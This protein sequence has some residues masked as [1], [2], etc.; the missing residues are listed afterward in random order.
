[1]FVRAVELDRE[2]VPSFAEHPFDL[3]AIRNLG[4]L[5]LRAPV[6]CFVGENGTGKST[7]LEA[8]A[9]ACGF[10]PEGG[11]RNLR[12]QTRASHSPLHRFVRVVRGTRRPRTGF[13]LRAETFYNLATAVDSIDEDP[14]NAG[15]NSGPPV[16]DAY[17]GRSLHAQ[18][19]GESFFSLFLARFSGNGLYLLDE[20]ESAL[21]PQRQLALLVRM[22]DLVAQGSQ[23][24]VATHAPILMAFPGAELLWFDDAGIRRAAFDEIEHVAVTRRFLGDPDSM[25]RELFGEDRGDP[26]DGSSQ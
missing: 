5:E 6:S 25:L 3:P 12:F 21:S 19:H 22:H 26:G 16:I 7:L 14:D 18:S 20:P 15:N 1:L 17:G 23:F 4:A 10:N 11:S 8:L 2:A 13:F 9:V 24:V